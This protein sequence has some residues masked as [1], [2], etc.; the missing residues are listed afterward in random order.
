M[1]VCRRDQYKKVL[2]TAILAIGQ[3]A[4]YRPSAEDD[5]AK[6]KPVLKIIWWLVGYRT[7][8]RVSC[9]EFLQN[10]KSDGFRDGNR[11]GWRSKLV[12]WEDKEF[13]ARHDKVMI[14]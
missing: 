7:C 12:Y 9:Q 14:G 11:E 2:E 1:T 6:E 3:E 5:S 13:G 8:G 10:R 4:W